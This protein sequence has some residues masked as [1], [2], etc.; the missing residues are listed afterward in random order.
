MDD[1]PHDSFFF[2]SFLN[3]Q[4]CIF[5]LV[6]T[7]FQS[8]YTQFQMV[9]EWS[10]QLHVFFI[11]ADFHLISN[12]FYFNRISIFSQNVVKWFSIRLHSTMPSNSSLQ[13]DCNRKDYLHAYWIFADEAFLL[14]LPCSV[15]G[16]SHSSE[17]H[18]FALERA[19]TSGSKPSW[20]QLV[21]LW[22]GPAYS[23]GKKT[24]EC[25]VVNSISPKIQNDHSFYLKLS[26][27]DR[28]ISNPKRVI[29]ATISFYLIWWGDFS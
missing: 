18:T 29:Q 28:S 17:G 13:H 1:P 25:Q 14:A 23:L 20:H 4:Q 2:S 16:I 12:E 11:F 21:C 24:F 22:P 15:D 8:K 9:F 3:S 27:G 5:N 7:D 6:S 26:T 19:S 10:K